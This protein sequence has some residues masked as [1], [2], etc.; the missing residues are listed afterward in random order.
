[1]R[2]SVDVNKVYERYGKQVEF[3]LVYL[4]EAHPKDGWAVKG[5][6]KVNDPTSQAKRNEVARTCCKEAKF[7][8]TAVVDTM[9][10]RTAVQWAGWPERLYV[11][12]KAGKIAY[13]GKQG[14][15]GFWPRDRNKRGQDK[16]GAGES[17]QAF[18]ERFL[19]P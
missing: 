8:F 18:L 7:K 11:V 10:D 6:S 2:T 12:D 1:M 19:K 17:L 16:V 5:W 13:A 14:P 4:R 15:W 3:I 9:N